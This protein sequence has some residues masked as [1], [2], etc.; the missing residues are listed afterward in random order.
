MRTFWIILLLISGVAVAMYLIQGRGGV[1]ERDP[2]APVAT[3]D[4]T[5]EIDAT[6]D[7]ED[8][9]DT[10][11]RVGD[12]RSMTDSAMV[13]EPELEQAEPD[14][15]PVIPATMPSAAADQ[16]AIAAGGSSGESIRD[17][18]DTKIAHAE[19]APGHIVRKPDGSLDVDGR[20]QLQGDGTEERPYR[21][22]W[23]YLVSAVETYQPRLGEYHMP[24]RIAMLHE[25]WVSIEGNIAFPLVA[26]SPK[27][28]LAMLNMW[29]GCCIG[30]PPTPYDAI[31]VRLAEPVPGAKRHSITFGAVTGKLKVEPYLIE[32][33][34]TGIYV[35]DDASLEQGL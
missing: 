17:G 16:P 2:L 13:L 29:D 18:L 31:E 20:F 15:A 12:V 5:P 3:S 35:M 32:S 28:I 23:E 22:T 33:W 14:V 21:L 27:E 9:S 1:E 4:S 24:Q 6:V 11:N 25:K 7:A 26:T 8:S 34:L 19:V 30:V 10:A